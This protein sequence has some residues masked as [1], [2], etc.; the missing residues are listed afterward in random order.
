M[1]SRPAGAGGGPV[2]IAHEAVLAGRVVSHELLPSVR[3]DSQRLDARWRRLQTATRGCNLS[4][5]A[6]VAT[7]RPAG[8]AAA[9][10]TPSRATATAGIPPGAP[11]PSSTAAAAA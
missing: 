2:R 4:A 5:Y 9:A 6:P 8:S 10:R 11:T 7:S 3:G 1:P